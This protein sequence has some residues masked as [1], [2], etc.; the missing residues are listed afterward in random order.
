MIEDIL[1]KVDKCI[2]PTDFIM[3]DT[4]EHKEIPIML[5]RPFLATT[6][7]MIDVQKG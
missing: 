1:V 2:F 6:R 4:E 7:A 5:G 3:L